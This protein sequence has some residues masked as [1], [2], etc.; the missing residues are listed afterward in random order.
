M[1][2]KTSKKATETTVKDFKY[3]TGVIPF[4]VKAVNPTLAQ[5][6]ELGIEYLQNEPEYIVENTY[7]NEGVQVKVKN[8]IVDFW[9]QSVPVEEHPDLDILTN[10]RFRINTEPWIGRSGKKQYINSYGRVSWADNI[11][12]LD[13]NKFFINEGTR[14]AHRGEE[15]IHKFL[16][17][18]LNMVYDTKNK[19]YDECVLDI[20]R[21]VAGD[22]SELEEIVKASNEY[23]VKIPVGV[24]VVEKDGKVRYYHLLYNQMFL[25]HNQSSTNRL[26]EYMNK[27]EFTEFKTGNGDLYFTPD[28]R[29]FNKSVKPDSDP[30][31]TEEPTETQQQVF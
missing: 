7:D 26:E 10:L 2:V 27:D 16:F 23:T 9:V 31:P 12:A 22:F 15:E 28:I 24:N 6:K 30:E 21:L 13:S 25:K 29:E 5:L 18:W 3:Y 8:V 19:E 11:E 14:Q 20:N 1:A 4:K 17:A